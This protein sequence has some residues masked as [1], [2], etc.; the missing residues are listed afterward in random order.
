M[1]EQRLID[2][3]KLIEAMQST[4]EIGMGM[5]LFGKDQINVAEVVADAMLD[6]VK[7]APT[8]DA[9]PV[10]HGH[11]KFGCGGYYNGILQVDLW[12]CSNCGESCEYDFKYCPYCG[13]KMDGNTDGTF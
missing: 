10:V 3:Y 6:D 1:T 4:K 11:W 8:V 5:F 13:A 12:D 2:A 9:K 7:D